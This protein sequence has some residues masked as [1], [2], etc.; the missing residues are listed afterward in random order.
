M[1]CRSLYRGRLRRGLAH[2]GVRGDDEWLLALEFRYS[3]L[4]HCGDSFSD[5]FGCKT[6][7]QITQF[8]FELLD[9]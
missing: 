7:F 8:R 9:E 6:L 5:I 4:H 1:H 3:L 2:R